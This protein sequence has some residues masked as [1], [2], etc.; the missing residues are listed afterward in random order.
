VHNL[1]GGFGGWEDDLARRRRNL[2]MD[3]VSIFRRENEVSMM[4][5]QIGRRASVVLARTSLD[6]ACNDLDDAVR[7]LSEIDGGTVMAN[8][9]LV[10]LLFRVV[11]ARRNL[12]AVERPPGAGPT[13]SLR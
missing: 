13:A 5:D 1:R 8:N 11:A 9:G 6:D 3:R 4:F 10:T 7:S 12:E 2:N